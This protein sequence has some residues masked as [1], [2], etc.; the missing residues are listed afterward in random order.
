MSGTLSLALLF[1]IPM[2]LYLI[3]LF[4]FAGRIPFTGVLVLA[5]LLMALLVGIGPVVSGQTGFY[6]FYF[7]VGVIGALPFILIEVV[8]TFFLWVK[9]WKSGNLR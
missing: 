7:I 3:W 4:K 9:R 6:P 5:V 2:V 8:R 1:G